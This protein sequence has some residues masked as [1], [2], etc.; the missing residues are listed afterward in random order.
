[1]PVAYHVRICGRVQG[2]FFRAWT[3]KEAQALNVAGWISNCSDGSVEARLEGEPDCVKELIRRL[4]S[5]SPRARVDSLDVE[6]AN[7]E[8]LTGFEVRS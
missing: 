8:G 5:G 2:V 3:R 7:V 1:M 6:T 4:R